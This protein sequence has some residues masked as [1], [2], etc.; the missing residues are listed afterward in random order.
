[1][2]EGTQ[3]QVGKLRFFCALVQHFMI[4]WMDLVEIGPIFQN[5][6][7]ADKCFFVYFFRICTEFTSENCIKNCMLTIL[8]QISG[9]HN[10]LS[11][12]TRLNQQP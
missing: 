1:M 11:G 3:Q 9:Q 2:K 10:L 5:G 7:D 6:I 8:V 4:F 12:D